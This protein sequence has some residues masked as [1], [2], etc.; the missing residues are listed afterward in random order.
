[1]VAEAQQ[2]A[3]FAMTVLIPRPHRFPPMEPQKPP[4][5]P[6][7]LARLDWLKGGEGRGGRRGGGRGGGGE[8]GREGEGGGGGRGGGERRGGGGGGREVSVIAVQ[9]V[10]GVSLSA[11][12]NS[13]TSCPLPT[14][15]SVK[16]ATT[17][18]VPP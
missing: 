11:L 12:A 14:N 15:A 8:G 4:P 16:C 2:R 17:R 3:R 1:M 7:R 9:V 13:T 18:S 6:P 5:S 10:R